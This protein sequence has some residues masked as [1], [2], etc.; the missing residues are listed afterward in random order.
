MISRRLACILA[1]VIVLAVVPASLSET[2]TPS[3]DEQPCTQIQ[4][5]SIPEPESGEAESKTAATPAAEHV[6]A[7]EPPVVRPIQSDP[8]KTI[9]YRP[10]KD[11]FRVFNPVYRPGVDK[12]EVRDL[13]YRPEMDKFFLHDLSSRTRT[14]AGSILRPAV[15]QIQGV[16]T[17][18][19]SEHSIRIAP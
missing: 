16:K 15:K 13:L 8:A 10:Q 4:P 9:L 11:K 1:L 14:A 12:F 6:T 5:S 19:T 7:L 2:Q 18:N 3:P 17:Y